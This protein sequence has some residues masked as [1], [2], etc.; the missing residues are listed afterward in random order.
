MS[1]FVV[2]RVTS[3]L[4]L[5]DYILTCR[6]PHPRLPLCRFLFWFLYRL[7]LDSAADLWDLKGVE[8]TTTDL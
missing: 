4:S 1:I 6:L 3:P 2:L 7:I 8:H 5:F